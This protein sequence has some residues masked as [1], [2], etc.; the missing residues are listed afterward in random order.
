MCSSDLLGIQHAVSREL[1]WP[2]HG[3]AAHT[4][5]PSVAARLDV[6]RRDAPGS[7]DGTGF[8]RTRRDELVVGQRLHVHMQV[9]SV[10]QRAGNL[11]AVLL[12]LERPA[13]TAVAAV[14]EVAAGTWVHG[15][16][17]EEPAWE[18]EASGGAADGDFAVF[19]RLA[20]DFQR[21]AFELGKFV[22]EEACCNAHKCQRYC[23]YHFR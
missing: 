18:D 23:K 9:D 10:E 1:G 8:R 7:D 14:A 3:V 22:E 13:G 17:E 6:A 16:D 15:G 11:R 12:D 5:V 4:A 2:H 20:Q 19:E 21:A